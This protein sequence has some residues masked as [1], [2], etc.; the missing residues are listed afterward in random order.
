[1]AVRIKS[2]AP[3]IIAKIPQTAQMSGRIS[4]TFCI[5]FMGFSPVRRRPVIGEHRLSVCVN[6]T[7]LFFE[8]HLKASI[9]PFE[10]LFCNCSNP[11]LNISLYPWWDSY[12][13]RIRIKHPLVWCHFMPAFLQEL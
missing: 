11:L 12:A 4:Q 2:K 8:A 6:V 13:T 5:F 9:F 3:F 7:E 10:I 1:M